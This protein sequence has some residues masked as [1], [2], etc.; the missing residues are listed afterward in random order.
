MKRIGV[1]I[2]LAILVFTFVGCNSIDNY[3][4]FP[5]DTNHSVDQMDC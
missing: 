4:T 2:I 1:F 3:Y 5:D